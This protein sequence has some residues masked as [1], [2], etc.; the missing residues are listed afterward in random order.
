[1]A[2]PYV[3]RTWVDEPSTS[4]PTSAAN[5]NAMELGIQDLSDALGTGTAWTS[6]TPTTTNITVGN[7]TV[8][9]AYARYGKTIFGRFNF[10]LGSTSA[11][12]TDPKFTLPF[13][14]RS[15]SDP[16]LFSGI[17]IDSGTSEFP[18]VLIVDSTT[19]V[20]ARCMNTGTSYGSLAFV[21]STVPMA[22]TTSDGIR[23]AFTYEAA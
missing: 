4:T 13:A 23:V 18:L 5:F 2:L 19:T 14:L 15:S 10:T 12:G 6:Y 21:S 20:A 9:A 11:M 3:R 16:I 7:G 8:T 22:W 1:M 17:H